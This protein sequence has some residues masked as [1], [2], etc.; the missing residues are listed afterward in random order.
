MGRYFPNVVRD[1][2]VVSLSR[3]HAVGRR[4]TNDVGSLRIVCRLALVAV[5]QFVGQKARRQAAVLHSIASI[6][7][8]FDVHP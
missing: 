2:I 6:P 4:I 3:I 8:G 7:L 1:N 5:P